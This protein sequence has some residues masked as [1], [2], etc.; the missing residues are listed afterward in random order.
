[1]NKTAVMVV[2][3]VLL[4]SL[5]AVT[6][7]HAVPVKEKNNDKFQTFS[8]TG[9]FSFLKFLVG[10]HM[11]IPSTDR[12]N[13]L[14]IEFDETMLAYDITIGEQTYHLNKDF[15]Y[16]GHAIFW[17]DDPVFNNPRLGMLYPSGYRGDYHASVDYT[18]D[19]SAISGGI[20]GTLTMRALHN[21]GGDPIVSLAGTGD[22]RNVQINA[23]ITGNFFDEGTL[24]LS[25][26]HEGYVSGWPE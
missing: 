16:I 21:A 5:S 22:L 1:M 23:E 26:F 14:F 19:F 6:F 20:E 4:F 18:F 10:E 2:T 25:I 9:T 15:K 3:L 8:V 12:V 7:A 13:K 11:Y 24:M 17:Y